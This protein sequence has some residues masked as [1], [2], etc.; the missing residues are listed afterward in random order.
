M[1][2]QRCGVCGRPADAHDRHVRSGLPDPVAAS[3]GQE[4]VPG[5]WLSQGSPE[6][7]V[8][9]QIPGAGPFVRALVPVRLTGGHTV[10]YGAWIGIHPDDLQR[11]FRVWW[12]PEHKDLRLNGVLANSIQPWGLLAAPVSLAVRDAQQTPYCVSSLDPLLSRV[13]SEDWPHE[14]VLQALP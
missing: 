12:K 2:E 5:A 6:S 11:A 13:M 8:M 4:R 1:A 9:M 14:N 10:T 7:S 3:P